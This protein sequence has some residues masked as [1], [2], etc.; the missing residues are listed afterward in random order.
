MSETEEVWRRG[1]EM[2]NVVIRPHLI[3]LDGGGSFIDP[4]WV[5]DHRSF[6][7]HYCGLVS[8]GYANGWVK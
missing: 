5:D 6:I 7:D 3:E 2:A 4:R 1:M 8:V